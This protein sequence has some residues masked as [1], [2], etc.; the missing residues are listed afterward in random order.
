MLQILN[1]I[2]KGIM[3]VKIFIIACAI[4]I[5]LGIL[6][7]I[8]APAGYLMIIIALTIAPI[9]LYGFG[10]GVYNMIQENKEMKAEREKLAGK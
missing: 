2:K 7:N 10:R 9:I 6:A 5:G 3:T 1:H 4:W 8:F